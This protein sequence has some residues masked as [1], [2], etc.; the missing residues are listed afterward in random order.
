V[1]TVP[2]KWKQTMMVLLVLFP[3]IM[4][5]FQYLYPLLTRINT[6]LRTFLGNVLTV[7]LIA[8]P[9]MPLAIYFFKWWLLPDRSLQINILGTLCACLVY[10]LEIYLLG[11]LP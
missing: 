5:E 9:C 11:F 4:L 6:T 8:W 10:L 2:P 1:R 7:I 3:L